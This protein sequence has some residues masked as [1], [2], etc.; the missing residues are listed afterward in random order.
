MGEST[1]PLILRQRAVQETVD[2]FKDR[3]LAYGKEDCAR[4]VAFCLKRM[5]VKVSLLS[6]GS[7]TS[8]VGAAR[9][10]KKMGLNGLPDA[11]DALGM[12]R[13]G[14][15]SMLAGDVASLP[16]EAFGG[17]LM[18]ALDNGRVFG[19]FD[20]RFQVGVPKMFDAA[21]RTI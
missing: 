13:I 16:A 6:A 18:L 14:P 17:A 3:P 5:G 9:T 4:M 12:P 10:L 15:A 19:Y 1:H 21:W 7:Y 8:P 2:R 20:G 11:M